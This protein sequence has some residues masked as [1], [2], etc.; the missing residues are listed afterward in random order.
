M[1]IGIIFK[2]S[3]LTCSPDPLYLFSIK[4]KKLATIA[5]V[6]SC[7]VWV[8]IL[9]PGCKKTEPAP[10]LTPVIS[11]IVPMQD[12]VGAQIV[13][14]GSGFST[15]A[16]ANTVTF[17]TVQ[18]T[19]ISAS[20]NK[21]V[22]V[23]P[24]GAS[25]APISVSVNGT[26]GTSVNSFTVTDLIQPL[27]VK[28]FSPLISGVGY[29]VKITGT[30][31]SANNS[32][33]T[34]TV[35][36][37]A[38]TVLTSSSTELL[39]SVPLTATTGKIVVTVNGK[40]VLSD[41]VIT[42]ITA[43]IT[44]I[45]GGAA[46]R[47]SDGSGSSAGFY[48]PAGII[49]DGNGNFYVADA[50]NNKIRKVTP[51]G[52][53]TTYAGTGAA[54]SLNGDISGATFAQPNSFA[55]DSHGNLFVSCN[56]NRN[57]RRI[58]PDGT[59][60]TFAGDPNGDKGNI[61]AVGTDARFGLPLGITIDKNDNIYVV[62]L[63]NNAIRKITPDGMVSTFAGGGAAGSKDS[64]GTFASFNQPQSICVDAHNN[65]YVVDLG[66]RKI[67]KIDEAAQVTSFAGSGEPGFKDDSAAYATFLEPMA[68]VADPS[69]NFYVT[70]GAN[71]NIRMITS[72][73]IVVTIAGNRRW[74]LVDGVG[75]YASFSQPYGMTIHSNGDIYLTDNY[76]GTIRKMVVR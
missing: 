54:G 15:M 60:S 55:F 52:V 7:V 22:V 39:F 72:N 20:E 53:V 32:E 4:M 71:Q 75:G 36:G 13:I 27:K 14:N 62:D 16:S 37:V 8:F 38:A 2:G 34:V 65:L 30:G 24:A 45:A 67:R 44:T 28:S 33:N 35:N 1:L 18:A 63:L 49:G 48:G 57:I 10:A 61:D 69:G 5:L 59:V 68:I 58:T 31:F 76:S 21:L 64:T 50:L 29:G 9:L 51:D 11:S 26:T 46:D 40:S 41:S 19:V 56:L 6:C 70:D 17:G 3:I 73:G 43:T 12:T 74:D 66:N 23:V 25:N 42:I 47:L